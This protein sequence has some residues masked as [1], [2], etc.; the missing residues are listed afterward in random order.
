MSGLSE[1]LE[2]RLPTTELERRWAAVRADMRAQG[3]DVLVMQNSNEHHGGTVRWFT[4]VP[5]RH[6]GP[7][8]VVFRRE[9]PMAVVT[10]GPRGGRT[11]PPADG[12]GLFRGVAAVLT[13]PYCTADATTD[14]TDGLLAA[15]A[16]REGE[17]ATIGIVGAGAIRWSFG[18]CL[19]R[20]LPASR[21][22]DASTL[23]DRHKAL[24]SPLEM[25]LVERCALLQD[26]VWAQVLATIRPGMREVELAAAA[27]HQAML[28]GSTE[29]LILTGSAPMGTP[30][31]KGHRHV[32]NRTLQAGDQFTML[33]EMNGPGG[34]YTE[35]GRT[36][37][38]GRASAE[39]RDEFALAVQ[40]QQATVE[41]LQP[42]A[43][44]SEIW[45]AHNAFMRAH[46]RPE[47]KRLFCHG[48]GY[49]LV[50]RPALRDGEP[51]ALAP[52]MNIVVHPTYATASVYSW[53]CD[54]YHLGPTGTR[55]LHRSPQVI[56]EI[57]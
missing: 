22:V 55:R 37:V 27:Y 38:L 19:R 2:F 10:S 35:L 48:Q 1:R 31:V 29:G 28:L 13:S 39:L 7:M 26:A 53:V 40:A 46:Q 44:P 5:A 43:S 4:D 3:I 18:D 24:K 57:D 41:R 45:A 33:I 15:T 52:D 54:N 16:I 14:D 49:D 9:G 21:F 30:A 50:E 51:M 20:A 25:E 17:H 34:Y 42:G 32:Q 12:S 56:T 8:T 23:V 11:V 6:G 47:E 36:C